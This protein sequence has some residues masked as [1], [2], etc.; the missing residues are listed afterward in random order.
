M[1]IYYQYALSADHVRWLG[2]PD[3]EAWSSI[4]NLDKGRHEKGG[5]L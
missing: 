5:G 4:V 3:R 1:F 2:Q